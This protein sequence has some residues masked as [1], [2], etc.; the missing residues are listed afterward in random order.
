MATAA[1]II[2]QLVSQSDL[3]W[4]KECKDLLLK[5]KKIV[6]EKLHNEN[7]KALQRFLND[8]PA[9]DSDIGKSVFYLS[10][11]RYFEINFDATLIKAADVTLLEAYIISAD[12]INFKVK[13]VHLIPIYKDMLENGK[14]TTRLVNMFFRKLDKVFNQGRAF[15]SYVSDNMPTEDYF[16]EKLN[17]LLNQAQVFLIQ[18]W[19]KVDVSQ[20]LKNSMEIVVSMKVRYNKDIKCEAPLAIFLGSINWDCRHQ[21]LVLPYFIVPIN[22]TQDNE[23]EVRELFKNIYRRITL[24]QFQREIASITGATISAIAKI[25]L[26]YK[27]CDA[28]TNDFVQYLRSSFTFPEKQ[29]RECSLKLWMSKLIKVDG[30]KV[31]LEEIKNEI[32]ADFDELLENYSVRVK[33]VWE[34]RKE[35][36]VDREFHTVTPLELTPRIDNL[37]Y[38]W[39]VLHDAITPKPKHSD[40]IPSRLIWALFSRT[41]YVS[42]EALQILLAKFSNC[43]GFEQILADFVH[44][45][46]NVDDSQIRDTILKNINLISATSISKLFDQFKIMLDNGYDGVNIIRLTFILKI[47]SMFPTIKSV[48]ESVYLFGSTHENIEIRQLCLKHVAKTCPQNLDKVLRKYM[49]KIGQTRNID[50][51]E[52]ILNCIMNLPDFKTNKRLLYQECGYVFD[53]NEKTEPYV[54]YLEAIVENKYQNSSILELRNHVE[55]CLMFLEK[56]LVKAGSN[57]LGD[58]CEIIQL[59]K[60]IEQELIVKG[61]QAQVKGNLVMANVIMYSQCVILTAKSYILILPSL[62]KEDHNSTDLIKKMLLSIM[63]IALRSRHKGIAD[64]CCS[65]LETFVDMVQKK[66]C[67]N[68]DDVIKCCFGRFCELYFSPT[69]YAR[70]LSCWRTMFIFLS[71]QKDLVNEIVP[72]L[73]ESAMPTDISSV[74]DCVKIRSLKTL[75]ALLS[76]SRFNLSQWYTQ[77]LRC[78]CAN[79]SNESYSIRS[80]LGHTFA[81]FVSE[82]FKGKPDKVPYFNFILEFKELFFEMLKQLYILCADVNNQALFFILAIFDKLVLMDEMYYS[83]ELVA[84]LSRLKKHFLK[85]FLNCKYFFLRELTLAC[86]Y[87]LC[88]VI[89]RTFLAENIERILP[90]ICDSNIKLSLTTLRDELIQEFPYSIKNPIFSKCYK[91]NARLLDPL[92]L[93]DTKIEIHEIVKGTISHSERLRLLGAYRCVALSHKMN[94]LDGKSRALLYICATILL[95]D[96]IDCV[97]CIICEFNTGPGENTPKSPFMLLASF[98]TKYRNVDDCEKTYIL[99][100][101]I[102]KYEKEILRHNKLYERYVLT[103]LDS[104][105]F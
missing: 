2:K 82:V 86:C 31:Y 68:L 85:M 9:L 102:Q 97:R 103:S 25:V 105:A 11:L 42:L 75:K 18:Q 36:D 50:M 35:T 44:H 22:V 99:Q 41:H 52:E 90:T 61:G 46:L 15:K 91:E 14:G 73:I 7:I 32:G 78:L 34:Y 29:A 1:D 63:D 100:N 67:A 64:S 54:Y 27:K 89:K 12:S 56:Q 24:N 47:C 96:E 98:R 94:E 69:F 51:V 23:K 93:T 79:Y 81:N 62:L 43:G 28:L 58:Y 45:N 3:L 38:G 74:S 16:L 57:K 55:N 72:R 66:G 101:F 92:Q 40:V 17:L 77:L 39:I 83:D 21:F 80:A 71:N 59:N 4:V 37:I 88:P 48:D 65:I 26:N 8:L 19:D 49:E 6:I 76:S 10:M 20:D 53:V 87:N 70:N 13:I 104:I 60:N 84:F 30:I 95:M 5:E 33:E